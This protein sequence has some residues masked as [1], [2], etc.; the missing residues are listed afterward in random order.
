MIIGIDID[1]TLTELKQPKI[2]IA[3]KY[4]KEHNL[5]Y[6]LISPNSAFFREMFD[7][8]IDVC[9]K[10]WF[11]KSFELLDNALPRENASNV[12]QKLKSLGHTILIITARANDW[13]DD[14]YGMSA[15]WLNRHHI[16]YDKILYGFQDKT[17]V[18]VDEKVD[19]FIDD[20]PSN[21]AKLQPYG[22]KTIMM[23]ACHNEVQDV[24]DGIRVKDWFE[25]ENYIY[26]KN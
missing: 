15:D 23:G 19:I 10:F 12:I 7:W 6:K 25:I 20:M 9:N 16:P 11:E 17:Q 8:P 14:P 13:H 3:E 1:D 24:Y 21:L 26:S 2:E 18:C 22:I 4:I 5:P